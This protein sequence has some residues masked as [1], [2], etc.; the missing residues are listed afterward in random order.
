MLKTSRYVL[1]E[2]RLL[3]PDQYMSGSLPQQAHFKV[4]LLIRFPNHR[5]RQSNL[6]THFSASQPRSQPH[7]LL[8]YTIF[9]KFQYFCMT[10]TYR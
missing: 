7:P 6:P 10:N 9:Y 4:H 5:Q 1:V 8:I 2:V 3:L